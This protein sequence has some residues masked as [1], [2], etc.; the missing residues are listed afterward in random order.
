MNNLLD[1]SGL[2]T[3][4]EIQESVCAPGF[5]FTERWKQKRPLTAEQELPG[6]KKD[7]DLKEVTAVPFA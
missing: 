5:Y 1:S 6:L 3:A 7:T 4:T 2:W